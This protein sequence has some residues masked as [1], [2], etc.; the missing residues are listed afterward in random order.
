MTLTPA[1][2]SYLGLFRHREFRAL[3]AGNALVSA[4]TSMSSLA[5]GTLVHSETGSP[6]LTA[7]V[8]FGP[9]LVQVVGA[10]TLMSLADTASPRTLLSAICVV[11]AFAFAMQAVFDLT[12]LGRLA[13]VFAAAY[14]LSISGGV[15]WGLLSEVLPAGGYALGRSAMNIS[16]GVMQIAG[17]AAAGLVLRVCPI[18]TVFWF[19]VLLAGVAFPITWFGIGAH[20]PR[21]RAPSGLAETWRGNRMLL[22][23][24]AS[25]TLLLALCLPNGLVAGC[26][27]L[28][29]PYA[30]DA[31]GFLFVSGAL[32][33]LAGDV[34]MG[35]VLR[36]AQRRRT[37][38]WLRI[39]LAVPFVA[40]LWHPPIGVAVVL[41]GV[42]SVGYAASLG[43]Q[44]L[45]VRL[46]RRELS[47]Q[48]LGAESAARITCQGLAAVLAGAVAEIVPTG[49][50]IALL[51]L[52]SLIV[53][54]LLTP[55]LRRAAVEAAL[56]GTL[57]GAP[58]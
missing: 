47:G 22:S 38:A 3:W 57:A 9:S 51:A 43:Q 6:L 35:R 48:V 5:L 42:A 15:R 27:A 40:L 41:I 34:L 56:A 29:V 23:R 58:D 28:F 36:P 20:P 19:A 24:P 54:A 4:A 45:L 8:M 31:A 2:T 7:L 33:M 39:L 32:G 18:D 21:R 12:T 10:G 52:C 25:R 16:A 49:F 37:A 53:S 44:E 30:G 13:I 46:T 55:A 17:F 50:A 26:E 1:E 14:V 11:L